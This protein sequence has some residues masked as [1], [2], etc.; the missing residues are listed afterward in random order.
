[1]C[2]EFFISFYIVNVYFL[3]GGGR[4]YVESVVGK[5]YYLCGRY[6]KVVVSNIFWGRV[7]FK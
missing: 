3:V 5:Y 4:K 1:M 7:L 6:G 2:R